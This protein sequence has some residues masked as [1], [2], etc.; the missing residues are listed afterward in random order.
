MV[1]RDS[2]HYVRNGNIHRSD[3]VSEDKCKHDRH[4]KN[5]KDYDLER[6]RF[7]ESRFLHQNVSS[8]SP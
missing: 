7:S 6:C 8:T 5:D 3:N 1:A 2:V 4:R